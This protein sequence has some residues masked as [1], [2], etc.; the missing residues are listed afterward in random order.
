MLSEQ[1]L[2]RT[3]PEQRSIAR[4][5]VWLQQKKRGRRGAAGAAHLFSV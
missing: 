1:P 4:G 3:A 5:A 2:V